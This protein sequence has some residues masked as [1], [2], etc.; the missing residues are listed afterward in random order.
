MKTKLIAMGWVMYY[1]CLNPCYKQ[2]F[3][4]P[5]KKGYEVRVR[6]KRKTFSILQNNMVIAGQFWAAQLEE[7]LKENGL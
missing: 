2:Q 4:H 3:N 1:E 7:K 5:D 6:T